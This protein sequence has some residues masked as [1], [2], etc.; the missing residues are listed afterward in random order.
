[1]EHKAPEGVAALDLSTGV[2][3]HWMQTMADQKIEVSCMAGVST[4]SNQVHLTV[5]GTGPHYVSLGA[6]VLAGMLSTHLE[7]P[8]GLTMEDCVSHMRDPEPNPQASGMASY[9]TTFTVTAWVDPNEA[10]QLCRSSGAGVY[11]SSEV[12]NIEEAVWN[13]VRGLMPLA[14]PT[15]LSEFRD[16]CASFE[17]M[18]HVL[19]MVFTGLNHANADLAQVQ[20]P[21]DISSIINEQQ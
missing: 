6:G 3:Q 1:M 7:I 20:V 2:F 11:G 9:T 12:N 16:V 19:D 13:M 10:D 15:S 18:G 14:P 21:D 5:M 8:Q 4:E 17:R